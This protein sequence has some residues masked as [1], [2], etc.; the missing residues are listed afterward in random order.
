[1]IMAFFGAGR[2]IE[3]FLGLELF[4]FRLGLRFPPNGLSLISFTG[5]LLE[6]LSQH[7][8]W[9]PPHSPQGGKTVVLSS[10]GVIT[11]TAYF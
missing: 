1:M 7:Q 5:L 8:T 6:P 2:I 3:L 10:D 9:E 11:F 4:L